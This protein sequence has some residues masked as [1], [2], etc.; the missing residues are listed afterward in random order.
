M[1]SISDDPNGR[2]RILFVAPDGSRKAIRL[3]KIDRKSAESICRHVEALLSAKVGG[4]TAP[5]DTATWLSVLGD[6]LKAKLAAVGLVD[7]PKRAILGEFLRGY[8]LTR[9]DVKPATLEVWQQPCRNLIDFFGDEKPLQA[10]TP[11]DCD[12]VRAWLLTEKLATTTFAKRLSFAR[13][14]FH[15]ARK[16]KLIDENPFAEVKIPTGDVSAGQRFIGRDTVQQL[17][18]FAS[19]TWRTIISLSRYGGLRCPSEVLSLEW[20]HIDWDRKRITVPSP[21]TEGY[22]GKGSRLIPFFPELLPFLEE[23]FKLAE[24]GQAHVIG[25]GHLAKA[26]GPKGWKGCNLRTSFGRLV[27]RAGL[28]VWPRP[29]HN[30]RSSRETELLEDYSVH[31]V[32]KW[33]GHDAK[34]C[35]KHYAQ[36]TDEH[37]ERASGGA[38]TG[39]RVAQNRAQQVDAESGGESQAE[40]GT[41]CPP[42]SSAIP[43]D[44]ERDAAQASSGEEGIRTLGTVLPVRGFSKAVLSTTQPPL[45]RNQS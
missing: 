36:T 8:I 9:P 11:G 37:F 34:V 1:A 12:Q 5:R 35:L 3:G 20:K 6:T 17:L 23:A 29:F 40:G 25:G 42:S 26:D 30:M 43:R 21:K 41:R 39:A 38:Q 22:E 7:A 31:V 33:M 45:R 15:V 19:P 44:S 27:K 13:T 2:R 4:Q 28:T 24:P 16:H 32:S 14:F 18:D 10:I